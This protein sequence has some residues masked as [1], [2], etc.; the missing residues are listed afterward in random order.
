MEKR[1]NQEGV[2]LVETLLYAVL[3][4]LMIAFAMF[5]FNQ[6]LENNLGQERRLEVETEANF[7]MKKILWALSNAQNINQPAAN[8]TSSNLSVNKYNFAQN[9]IAF[10]LAEDKVKISK[11]GGT[12]GTPLI[13]S[14]V[15]IT[16]LSFYRSPEVGNQTEAIT[17]TLSISAI[18][19][20]TTQ[21]ASTTL[22]T[23]IYL[24]K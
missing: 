16:N 12:N 4:S 2:T 14:A 17:I 23:K 13:S 7:I 18:P 15:Q 1:K 3:F 9:P 5:S 11:A 22:Q 21:T 10:N 19:I 6:M 20:P 24:K 8:S